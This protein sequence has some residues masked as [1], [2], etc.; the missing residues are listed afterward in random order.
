MVS[1]ADDAIAYRDAGQVVA[2]TERIVSDTDNTIATTSWEVSQIS[3]LRW[4]AER[5]S[6]W[7]EV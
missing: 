3:Q 7:V 5:V 2:V 4:G 1:D 6:V